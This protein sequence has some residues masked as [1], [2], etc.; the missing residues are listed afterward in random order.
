MP[1]LPGGHC[2]NAAPFCLF[3]NAAGRH[4]GAITVMVETAMFLKLVI[5]LAVAALAAVTLTA[6]SPS[7]DLAGLVGQIA[8]VIEAG[9]AR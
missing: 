9:N 5:W 1:A 2:K 7:G 4:V 8:P 6:L 3:S